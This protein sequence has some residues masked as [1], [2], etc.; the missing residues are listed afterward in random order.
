M[1]ACKSSRGRKPTAGKA[2]V[3]P[4]HLAAPDLSKTAHGRI[5]RPS[6]KKASSASSLTS[7]SRKGSATASQ[8]ASAVA[9]T[10]QSE[11]EEEVEELDP[12]EVRQQRLRMMELDIQEKELERRKEALEKRK[13]PRS[14][15]HSSSRHRHHR[16]HRSRSRSY[17]SSRSYSRS[18]TRSRSRSRDRHVSFSSYGEQT[19]PSLREIFPMVEEKYLK[20]VLRNRLHPYEFYKLSYI[21]K[22]KK[23]DETP[24]EPNFTRLMRDFEVFGQIIAAFAEP[25]IVPRLQ[26]ALAIY[27]IRLSVKAVRNTFESVENFHNSFVQSCIHAG[28]QRPDV[29][30]SETIDR[31]HFL[32]PKSKPAASTSSYKTGKL[33][34]LA[35]SQSSA[36]CIRFNKGLCT[37]EACRYTHACSNCGQPNHGA[38]LCKATSGSNMV[39]LGD[40]V[41]HT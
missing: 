10:A 24:P 40:R 20:R 13:E 12:I 26:Q 35:S 39:P 18:R 17:T 8:L 36:T 38:H 27:R 31:T 16:Y 15:R 34:S 1:V 19:L 7:A 14:P 28:P 2:T 41:A 29:W 4:E 22:H 21:T 5:K 25:N 33:A 3:A 30:L 11:E 6:L 23:G 9:S 37:S 32:Q